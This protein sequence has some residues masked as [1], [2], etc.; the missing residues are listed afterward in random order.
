MASNWNLSLTLSYCRCQNTLRFLLW[1]NRPTRTQAASFLKFLDHTHPV[2]LFWTSYQFVAEVA[3]YTT[4]SN[5]R[6]QQPCLQRDSNPR[7]AH[8]SG[9]RRHGH[10]IRHV[11]FCLRAFYVCVCV[12]VCAC[13]RVR[14][15]VCVTWRFSRG[16]PNVSV[17]RRTLCSSI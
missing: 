11:A 17:T 13:A 2:G 5:T 4:P 12:C 8:S 15:C 3:T 1:L 16:S 9:F 7:S 10:R 6:D 14:A